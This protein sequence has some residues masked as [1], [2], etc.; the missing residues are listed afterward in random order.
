MVLVQLACLYR[1]S[2]LRNIPTW[3]LGTLV[4]LQVMSWG[5]GKW[6]EPQ[7][8]GCL[9]PCPCLTKGKDMQCQLGNQ[10]PRDSPGDREQEDPRLNLTSDYVENLNSRKMS[11]FPKCPACSTSAS[12]KE[13]EGSFCVMNQDRLDKRQ[14][15]LK[16]LFSMLKHGFVFTDRRLQMACM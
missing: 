8:R 15:R 6:L 5:G 7:A 13:R 11:P 16:P 14:R 1:G 10:T 2:L 9:A 12:K 3:V 4:Q